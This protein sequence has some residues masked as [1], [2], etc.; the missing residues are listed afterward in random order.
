M[1][2]KAGRAPAVE[3]IGS[4]AGSA[5]R[6][7]ATPAVAVGRTVARMP[8]GPVVESEGRG[9]GALL[10]GSGTTLSLPEGAAEGVSPSR[11]DAVGGGAGGVKG[12]RAGGRS[13]P[14]RLP[15]TERSPTTRKTATRP[16]RTMSSLLP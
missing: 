8:P 2:V 5:P 13:L 7:A 10:V 1:V 11:G 12:S 15:S 14:V 9:A 3:P 16:L 4:N 6:M